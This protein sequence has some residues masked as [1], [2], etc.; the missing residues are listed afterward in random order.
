MFACS[1][2]FAACYSQ[3]Q[4]YDLLEKSKIKNRVDELKNE[5]HMSIIRWFLLGIFL[6][7]IT[8]LL[9]CYLDKDQ[10]YIFGLFSNTLFLF[11]VLLV[12]AKWSSNKIFGNNEK[13]SVV[14]L[15]LEGIL[16]FIIGFV[17]LLL[18][19]WLLLNELFYDISYFLKDQLLEKSLAILYSSCILSLVSTL[20]LLMTN[21]I[22]SDDESEALNDKGIKDDREEIIVKCSKE[23]DKS[24]IE[25]EKKK[26][27]PIFICLCI[28]VPALIQMKIVEA[29]KIHAEYTS[30]DRYVAFQVSDSFISPVMKMDFKPLKGKDT[31]DYYLYYVVYE[32]K[33]YLCLKP[34]VNEN[35]KFFDYKIRSEIKKERKNKNKNDEQ[36]E[37]S[38]IVN[39]QTTTTYIV[40]KSK[41]DVVYTFSKPDDTQKDSEKTKKKSDDTDKE[42]NDIKNIKESLKNDGFTISN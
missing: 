22:F 23:A 24:N 27:E 6:V 4:V 15:Y 34:I 10:S 26:Y 39:P 30:I 14:I 12:I 7:V 20:T 33:D 3:R 38:V 9:Q 36:R 11:P 32:N 13:R 8:L 17:I 41:V 37:T 1:C 25:K 2:L 35:G 16:I 21:D 42:S 5:L 40:N 19:G 29:G 31:K 28:F 18:G